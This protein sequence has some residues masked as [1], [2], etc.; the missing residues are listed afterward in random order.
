MNYNTM[1]WQKYYELY[2]I[3]GE[4][5]N[6]WK[7]YFVSP[8]SLSRQTTSPTTF[9]EFFNTFRNLDLDSV[10]KGVANLQKTIGLL[11]EIGLGAGKTTTP[12]TN[13]Y[14]PRPMYRYFDD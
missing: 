12:T 6:I 10:Q 2:D 1:T 13:T 8:N 11:Q 7:E 4:N 9:K 14:E 5:N 3:Y